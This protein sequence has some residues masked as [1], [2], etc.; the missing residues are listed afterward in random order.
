MLGREGGATA[1]E[2]YTHLRCLAETNKCTG[3]GAARLLA[4]R[5]NESAQEV[6]KGLLLGMGKHAHGDRRATAR[7]PRAHDV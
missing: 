2:R 4:L 3:G 5:L 6:H 7:R 1:G